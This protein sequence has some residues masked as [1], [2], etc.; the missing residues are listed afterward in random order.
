MHAMRH[1]NLGIT[2]ESWPFI[3]GRPLAELAKK[4]AHAILRAF[5]ILQRV[6]DQ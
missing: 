4:L 6:G 1:K 3:G 5:V 2:V